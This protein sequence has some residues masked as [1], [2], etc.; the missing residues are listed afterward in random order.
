M[1]KGQITDRNC[2]TWL[3][4]EQVMQ[5]R[6]L[7]AGPLILPG[8]MTQG[9]AASL[10]RGL[11]SCQVTDCA[12]R[13]IPLLNTF[14]SGQAFQNEWGEWQVRIG[15]R[16]KYLPRKISSTL[17]NPGLMRIIQEA[18]EARRIKAEL[19]QQDEEKVNQIKEEA[20]HILDKNESMYERILKGEQE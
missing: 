13:G 19:D 6:P 14:Y 9:A 5:D 16:K 18:R 1:A 4:Y 7:E 17:R 2:T 8:I 20:D 12:D 10:A 11:S 3:L 15:L